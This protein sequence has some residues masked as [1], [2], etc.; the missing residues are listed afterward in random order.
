[1]KS[2]KKRKKS[3]DKGG[4]NNTLTGKESELEKQLK[5]RTNL[6]IGDSMILRIHGKDLGKAVGHRVRVK[7]FSGATTMAMNHY[8][9]LNLESSPNEV[10]LHIGTNDS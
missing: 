7:P 10:I 5:E 6:L 1:M 2:K 4:P 3:K 9:K 8:L